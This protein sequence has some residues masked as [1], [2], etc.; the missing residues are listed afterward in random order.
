MNIKQ[1]YTT[2]IKKVFNANF[3]KTVED[4]PEIH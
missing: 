3:P 2:F 4:F 1:Q